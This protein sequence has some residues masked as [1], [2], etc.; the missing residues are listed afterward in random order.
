M[1]MMNR[2]HVAGLE[3][4]EALARAAEAIWVAA[5]RTPWSSLVLVPA[6]RDQS[7]AA[8]A[9][10]VAAAGSAQRGEPVEGLD[11]AGLSLAQSRPVADSLAEGGR[12]YRRVAAV[13]CP[14]ASQTALLLASAAGSAVLV[15]AEGR[16]AMADARHLI[17][18]I[19]PRRF[20]GAV[21][22][23]ASA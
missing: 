20:L 14:L 9:L 17:E 1:F 16:T 7:T 10:A 6:D 2:N 22:L 23:K 12:P 21:L 11:L 15:V 19:G 13:D 5:Q 3:P 4:R 8:L 18:L